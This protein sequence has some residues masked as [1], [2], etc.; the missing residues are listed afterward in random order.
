MM[1]WGDSGGIKGRC[2]AKCHDAKGPECECMCGGAYHGTACKPGGVDYV[3]EQI[4]D[5]ILLEAKRKA[6][7]AGFIL[8]PGDP[9]TR[10]PLGDPARFVQL[11]EALNTW[12]G[13]PT[14]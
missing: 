5:R 2:D 13:P 9:Q 3:Q 7:A 6:E 10:L 12:L 8:R 14:A 4:G 1:W 11:A